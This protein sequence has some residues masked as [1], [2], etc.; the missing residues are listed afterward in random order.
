MNKEQDNTDNIDVDQVKEN[1]DD[2]KEENL[3][4]SINNLKKN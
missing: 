4:E 2:K 3:D 1:F